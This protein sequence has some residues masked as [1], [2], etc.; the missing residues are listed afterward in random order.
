MVIKHNCGMAVTHRLAEAYGFIN[1]LQHRGR[2]AAGIAAIG[3]DRIDVIKWRGRVNALD[4]IALENIFESSRYHTFFAHV[5]YATSGDEGAVLEDAHPH[6]IGGRKEHRGNHILIWDC[7]AAAVHNG[8]VDAN[9]FTSIEGRCSSSCDTERMLHLYIARGE[10]ELMRSVPGAFTIAIADKRR[11]EV[12]VMRDSSG[13]KPGVLGKI[14]GKYCVA[15]ED[16]AIRKNSAEVKEDLDPGTI[17]YLAAD[18]RYRKQFVCSPRPSYCFFEWNYLAHKDSILNGVP[19]HTMR[20]ILGRQLAEQG[21]IGH[22]DIVTFLPRCP[23]IA[24]ESF[25]RAINRSC[26]PLFYKMKGERSFQGTTA[27]ERAVSIKNNLYLIPGVIASIRGKIIVVVDDSIV[28]GNNIRRARQLLY[29]EAGVKE[30]ILLS[31]TPPLGII[32]EDNIPRGCMFGVDMPPHADRFIARGRT[33][34]QI[35]AEIQ[36]PVRY[37][38]V[39]GMLKAFEACGL[40]RQTLCTYCIGGR[41]PFQQ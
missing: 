14:G 25:A 15:S 3:R 20:D 22:V 26:V 1:S 27:E 35:S 4:V 24:A 28:R 31:Y 10:Y 30:A 29:E 2:E 18:G 41:H 19:V 23:E 37:L 33:L 40:P 7:D 11:E 38:S 39:E 8:Q 36:M 12:I 16:I 34:D 32:G 9:F 5:R 21:D 13:I 17:Y 6:V